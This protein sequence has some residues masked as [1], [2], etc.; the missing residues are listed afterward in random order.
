LTRNV[1]RKRL[2]SDGRA[3]VA[4]QRQRRTVPA[5]GNDRRGAA[6]HRADV[7]LAKAKRVARTLE[8]LAEGWTYREI[9]AEM[10]VSLATAYKDA[11]EAIA[12][13]PTPA[14]EEW[15]RVDLERLDYLWEKLRPGIELGDDKAVNAALRVLERRSRYLGLDAPTKVEATGNGPVPVL[16]VGKLAD[17]AAANSVGLAAI[18]AG[19]ADD[20]VI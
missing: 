8:L 3:N 9:S 16:L 5:A 4:D 6:S 12:A 15:R 1:T 13:L 18:E 17:A 19:T 11:K 14:A 20:E 10:G 7:R 2:T